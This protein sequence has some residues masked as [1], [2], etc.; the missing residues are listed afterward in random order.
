MNEAVFVWVRSSQKST[1]WTVINHA[2]CFLNASQNVFNGLKCNNNIQDM[3]FN[4]KKWIDFR[5]VPIIKDDFLFS[6]VLC[7]TFYVAMLYF[8]TNEWGIQLVGI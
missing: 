5:S 8:F 3:S 1:F 6:F 7:L 2:K 4:G